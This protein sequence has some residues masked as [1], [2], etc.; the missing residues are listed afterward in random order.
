MTASS[1]AAPS[2]RRRFHLLFI[3]L[4]VIGAGNS[5]LL[6][7]APPL[8]RQLGLSDSSVGWIFSLSAL[9][10]VFTSPYWGRL[11]DRVGRK[12]IVAL[13]L[14]AYAVSMG[15]FGFVVLLGLAGAVSGLTLFVSLMM[16]RAI[17]GS[18]GSAASPAS[19]AYIADRTTRFERTEQLAGLNAAFAMGQAFGPAICAALAAWVGLVFP[20]WLV[21]ALAVLAAYSIWRYLPENTPP[22]GERQQPGDWREQIALAKDGRLSAY[23]VYGFALSVVAGVTVQVFGLFMMDRLGVQ[24]EKGAEL[25]AAG[26]MVNALALLAT[27]MAI[28]P[29]LKLTPRGLMAWGSG[30]TACGIAIQIV[31]P[32]L[33]ALLVAQAVQGLGSGLARSGFSGGAS[34]A[35]R[36]DEQGS[37]AGLVVAVNGA[38]FVFSPIV[39]GVAYER[40]GMTAPLLIAVTLL[41]AMLLFT[42]RSRRLR[43]AVAFEQA[44][45]E[46]TT[47]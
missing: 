36:P 12:P 37:A 33:G 38:G 15:L 35:V 43:A 21:A 16:A 19:Q 31:A 3:C 17:F 47:P 13:G 42:L 22:R 34:V 29:R 39:G 7:V 32:T 6:A 44:P 46:P 41:L 25:A 30:L 5:M 20:I 28:L 11:S 10:W 40:L 14:S 18:F 2:P 8:V 27:Q 24:G 9:L 26:F 23:L 45:S 4:L 1:Q